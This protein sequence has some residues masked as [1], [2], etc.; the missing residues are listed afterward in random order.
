MRVSIQES[1][2]RVA[3]I[4]I[5]AFHVLPSSAEYSL[6]HTKEVFVISEKRTR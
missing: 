4:L 3:F 2:L 5:T 6:V 1:D